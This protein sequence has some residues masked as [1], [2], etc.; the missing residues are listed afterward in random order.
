MKLIYTNSAG[1]SVTFAT[2]D[3]LRGADI[4]LKEAD[5]IHGLQADVQL[6]TQYG[7]DGGTPVSSQ[8]KP[9]SITLGC[10]IIR[11]V[12][13]T[14]LALLQVMDPKLKG[15]LT[16]QRGSFER[17]INCEIEEAPAFERRGGDSFTVDL[18]APAPY[19][20]DSAAQRREMATWT[21]LFEWPLDVPEEG[22]SF[23]ERDTAQIVNMVNPGQATVGMRIEIAAAHTVLN[24]SISSVTTFKR[25]RV[26][27]EM[28]GG[29]KLTIGTGYGE[30]F[31]LLRRAGSASDENAMRYMDI[32]D[33]NFA[34]LRLVPGDNLLRYDAD[35]GAEGLDITVHYVPGYLGV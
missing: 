17:R 32:A 20:M 12:I 6:V 29:D 34:F 4:L 25:M 27:L 31:A 2:D 7:Q 8:L 21:D 26:K 10:K 1:G 11:N 14:R 33:P 16:L 19:W 28:H 9:R 23:G 35:S 30:M 18:I 5:G 3:D 22:I 15:V 24:P 13:A